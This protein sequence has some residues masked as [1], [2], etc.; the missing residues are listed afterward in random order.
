MKSIETKSY[1]VVY[2][3]YNYEFNISKIGITTDMPSRLLNLMSGCGCDLELLYT[4]PPISNYNIIERDAHLFFKDKRRQ[5][6]EWFN[7]DGS[8]AIMFISKNVDH[9]NIHPVCVMYKEGRTISELASFYCVSRAYVTKILK[10]WNIYK[11]ENIITFKNEKLNKKTKSTKNT[12]IPSK[13]RRNNKF[14]RIRENVYKHE[15][16]EV[17]KTRV[18]RNGEVIENFFTNEKQAVES[19]KPCLVG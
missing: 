2:V 6:G 12:N 3:I 1:G 14:I 7:M 19:L 15:K 9:K 10:N 17:Y 18:F 13:Y 8:E 5:Y 4:T 11:R 16:D